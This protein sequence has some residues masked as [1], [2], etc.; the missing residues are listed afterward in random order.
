MEVENF[1]VTF[2]E[3]LN[4]SL[5]KPLIFAPR[6]PERNTLRKISM[7]RYKIRFRCKTEPAT[8]TGLRGFSKEG[9]Y[10]GRSYNGLFEVHPAWGKGGGA[11]KMLDQK[12]FEKYFEVVNEVQTTANN[13]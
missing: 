12:T 11:S 10:E 1:Y 8:Q 6:F 7:D 2:V 13:G 4:Y 3:I 9:I 5:P